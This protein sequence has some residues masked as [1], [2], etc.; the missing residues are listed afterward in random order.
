[1][2][3]ARKDKRTLLS[4]KIRYKSATLEDF[5]ERYSNDISRGGV[6]IKAKKPLAVGTL[7][8][9]EFMLQ[10][11]STLIHGV[12]RVVWRREEA[13]SD[14]QNPAGMGIKFIKMDP[15]SRSV[16]QRIAEGRAHPGVFEQGKEGT[17]VAPATLSDPGDLDGEDRTQVR[18]VSE[19]LVSAM[20]EGG[21]GQ[22]ATREAR[23]GAERARQMGQPIGATRTVAARGAF[24]AHLDAPNQKR[25]SS[26]HGPS[27][28]AMSAFGGTSRSAGSRSSSAAPSMDE[29]DA[30]EDF[31]DG[32]TTRIQEYPKSDFPDAAATVIAKEGS[33]FAAERRQT[34]VVPMASA[35]RSPLEDAV[36]DLFGPS[37]S[38]SFGPAPGEF[39]DASLLDPAVPT[40]PP[41]GRAVP[42]APGVPAEALRVAPPS[43]RP[44]G[45][46]PSKAKRRGSRLW[47]VVPLLVLLLGAAGFAV[48]QAGLAG[49][50]IDRVAASLGLGRELPSG[51]SMRMPTP[52]ARPEIQNQEVQPAKVIG[53][54]AP[55]EQAEP[56]DDA[57]Q[58][59][60][61]GEAVTVPAAGASMVKLQV[62]S[63]PSGAFVSVDGK[64]VGRTP[65]EL[66]YAAGTEISLLS[67]ARGYSPR[68]QQLTVQATQ[69]AV[70]LVLAPLPY[71]V[72]VV[73]EP[74][75]ARATAV[76][77]GEVITPGE[78]RFK[79]VPGPRQIVI[80]KDGYKTVTKSVALSSFAEES[81]RMATAISL[82]LEK[83]PASAQAAP[84]TE[85]S[86][87][88]PTSA[89]PAPQPEEPAE[90]PVEAKT[91]EEKPAA[92][93]TAAAEAP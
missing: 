75:G 32:D 17:Q 1:M 20:E 47:L 73:T 72:Q 83:E 86:A 51:R 44:V 81:G 61:K 3:D 91:V 46:K 55:S 12:G 74:A 25:G 59:A 79:S 77:G 36:P 69:S 43:V 52:P 2:A 5:I 48:W 7:L 15:E 23:A 29:L 57:N 41:P 60:M 56:T 9:F 39:I 71:V 67:R 84:V 11:Q 31:L 89:E 21:A 70:R 34:P 63:V 26:A 4:M 35:S 14:P 90:P 66:E 27:R 30:E 76:G 50:W 49:D 58:P 78:L 10:D 8:K 68:R 82:T 53:E 62:L 18:H 64:N 92:S 28:G 40:V 93:E 19:F 37:I 33:P 65:L 85:T 80:S 88:A 6:F 45:S 38:D 54:R 24:S 42:V 16:V 13:E 87:Q 22:A